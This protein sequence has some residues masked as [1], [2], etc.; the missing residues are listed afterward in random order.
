MS[1][2]EAWDVATYMDSQPRPQDA[3]FTD[4][5]EE[6]RTRF[7]ASPTSMYDRTVNGVFLGDGRPTNLEHGSR[8]TADGC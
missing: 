7:H 5:I 6:T 4:S 2:Q 8:M 3:R 1:D